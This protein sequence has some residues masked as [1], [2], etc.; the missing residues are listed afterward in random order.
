MLLIGQKLPD[1]YIQLNLKPQL[2]RKITASIIKYGRKIGDSER[3]ISKVLMNLPVKHDPD[4]ED[5]I[6]RNL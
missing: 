5:L 2:Y 6:K 4:I 1:I 3:N